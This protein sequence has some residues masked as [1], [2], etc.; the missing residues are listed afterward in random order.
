MAEQKKQQKPQTTESDESVTTEAAPQG[1]EITEKIDDLL[2]EERVFPLMKVG[3]RS[4][5]NEVGRIGIHDE[6][7]CS[8]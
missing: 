8:C 3:G 1:E 4:I 7:R 2:D 5:Q 6:F